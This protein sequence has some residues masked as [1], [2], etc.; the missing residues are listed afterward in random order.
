MDHVVGGGEV[1]PR[2]ARLERDQEEVAV[3]VLEGVD[4][5]R[6][7]PGRGLA[8]EVLVT[9]AALVEGA[10]RELQVADELAED[11]SCR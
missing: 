9:D 8:V 11:E 3:A 2:A 4:A 1:E 6:A 5:L 10:A 7:L